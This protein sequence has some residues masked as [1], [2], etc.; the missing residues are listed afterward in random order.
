MKK[1]SKLLLL[2]LFTGSVYLSANSDR[3]ISEHNGIKIWAYYWVVRELKI[4]L[5]EET[6]SGETVRVLE[7]DEKEKTV[8][9]N[10]RVFLENVSQENINVVTRD[11]DADDD[12]GRK[13]LKNTT[14]GLYFL[15][16]HRDPYGRVIK[17]SL[18]RFHPVELKPGE[19]TELPGISFTFK[20]NSDVGKLKVYYQIEQDFGDLFGVWSGKLDSRIVEKKFYTIK[21][22]D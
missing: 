19:V 4:K 2:V 10:C 11:R 13:T 3:Q 6:L 15:S 7:N 12:G 16:L 20:D 22:H 21:A 17:P 18:Q 1:I 14:F 8:K 5:Y 9:V